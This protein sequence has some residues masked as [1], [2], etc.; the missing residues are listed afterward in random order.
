MAYLEAAAPTV[1]GWLMTYA[2]HSTFLLG[3][4]ALASRW[5]ADEHRWLDR[6][7]KIAILGALVT[8]SVQVASDRAPLGGRWT[9]RVSHPATVDLAGV[10]D[11]S[12][13]TFHESAMSIGAPVAP[14]RTTDAAS[15]RIRVASSVLGPHPSPAPAVDAAA[16]WRG[17]RRTWPV[18]AVVC[19]IV[20]AAVGVGR[21]GLGHVRVRRRLS[22]GERERAAGLEQLAAE[23]RRAGTIIVPARISVT[24]RCAVPAALT[25]REIV[26]PRRFL[27]E[28]GLDEQRAALAHEMAHVMRRDPEWLLVAVILERLFFFQPLNRM[29]RRRLSASAE[30]LCDE[31]AVRQTGARLA[32]ARCLAS[33]AS[34]TSHATDA[35]TATAVAMARSDS[36]LVRRVQRILDDRREA[37]HYPSLLWLAAVLIAVAAGAPMVSAARVPELALEI[38]RWPTLTKSATSAQ[39][40]AKS[41]VAAG[42]QE[43]TVADLAKAR[44]QLRVQRPPN[45]GDSLE[46]RWQWALDDANRR[47]VNDFWIVYTFETPI[48]AQHVMMSDSSD[49]SLVTA[50]GKMIRSGPP[51]TDLLDQPP[52][53]G[54]PGNVAVMLR[55]S[56]GRDGAIARGGY[57]S[58]R[59]GFDFGRTPVFWL[60]FAP[61]IE[62]FRRLE[63]L[64]G[65]VSKE[66][67]QILLIEAASLHPTTDVVLPFLTRLLETSHPVEIRREAAEGFD[68]HHDPRSVE[69][70]L[71][72]A[73]NDPSDEV[74]VEAA[75]TIG[76]VQTPQSIP[77][78][79][80]LAMNSPDAGVRREAAEAFADQ[81]PDR[82]LPAL[83]HLISSSAHDD[84]LVEAIEALGDIKDSRASTILLDVV[85][86]H[87]SEAAR[88]EAVETLGSIETDESTAALVRIVWEHTDVSVQREAV[89]TLGEQPEAAALKELERIVRDHPSEE[90]QAEAL[91]TIADRSEQPVSGLLLETA[92]SGRSARVRR[93]AIDALSGAAAD[94]TDART[95]DQIEQTIENAIFNDPDHSVRAEAI[96]ALEALPRERASRVVRKV[97]DRHPDPE[98]REEAAESERERNR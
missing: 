59:L 12:R 23:L 76:E 98:I 61:E 1:L 25:G 3:A 53:I 48:H 16:A 38:S 84:A 80:D 26:V 29:A 83:E 2:V 68:H 33:V 72:T 97:I 32:L 5:F 8:T 51:L 55:Y 91:E 34:W 4:A 6:L 52:A 20:V 19:W 88:Q 50:G 62:S 24:A 85:W 75:E 43:W 81:P 28:L 65:V 54:A 21:I 41:G 64:T 9:L 96:D 40:G 58:T 11:S 36:P 69:I 63:E 45:P 70:L 90:V 79:T 7:W 39:P 92:R 18:T 60:G 73:R 27:I 78:L 31:W 82:A 89:E 30:F 17:L 74:R 67:V 93:E 37:A 56:A 22:A 87:G 42:P 10:S 57:R 71:R 77:A 47:G 13:P 14:I 49:G 44:A 94:V 66:K 86:K 15:T 95:L 35:H 46:R